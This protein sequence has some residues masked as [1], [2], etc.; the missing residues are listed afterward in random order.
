M[1][2]LGKAFNDRGAIFGA[3]LG[4]GA[5]PTGVSMMAPGATPTSKDTLGSV[6]LALGVINNTLMIGFQALAG[7]VYG[8]GSGISGGGGGGGGGGGAGGGVGIGARSPTM[9]GVVKAVIGNTAASYAALGDSVFKQL[10]QPANKMWS[11]GFYGTDMLGFAASAFGKVPLAGQIIG[12]FHDEAQDADDFKRRQLRMF[13]TGGQGS[14]NAFTEGF[15][16]RDLSD[17]DVTWGQKMGIGK[18]IGDRNT[19]RSGDFYR[20]AVR[21]GYG[22]SEYEGLV[23]SAARQGA[24]VQ[25][26]MDANGAPI[27]VSGDQ[28]AAFSGS[29]RR[30][31]AQGDNNEFAKMLGVSISSGLE[32]G[33]WGEMIT[34]ATRAAQTTLNVAVNVDQMRNVANFVQGGGGAMFQPGTPNFENMTKSY[35]GLAGDKNSIFAQQ[36]AWK[37]SGGNYSR[38]QSILAKSGMPGGEM[39]PKLVVDQFWDYPFVQDWFVTVNRPPYGY[40]GDLDQLAYA[41]GLLCQGAP[42]TPVPDMENILVMKAHEQESAEQLSK[43][44][45][46]SDFFGEK[47]VLPKTAQETASADAYRG[48]TAGIGGTQGQEILVPGRAGSTGTG[49]PPAPPSSPSGMFHPSTWSN[50]STQ[51]SSEGSGGQPVGHWTDYITSPMGP[52]TVNGVP[53]DHGMHVDLTFPAGAERLMSPCD[54]KVTMV[55]K[56]GTGNEVG[57]W[58]SIKV[59][60][61]NKVVTLGHLVPSTIAVTVGQDVYEGR[62][63]I[64]MQ[65]KTDFSE[66]RRHVDVGVTGEDGKPMSPQDSGVNFDSMHPPNIAP[67]NPPATE[68]APGMDGGSGLVT[69]TGAQ[70]SIQFEHSIRVHVTDARTTVASIGS[71]RLARG[72][73]LKGIS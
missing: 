68:S 50:P 39:D 56:G 14:M 9:N 1:N 40:R 46:T 57:G 65:A 13:R 6:V 16:Q 30:A 36:A 4:S 37:L 43:Y 51:S 48:R 64:G 32:Q 26:V 17:S 53:S 33:R 38:M 20:Y 54:G 67:R 18:F 34:W 11:S 55:N 41:A 52:R 66:G 47:A 25:T 71:K 63:Y 72:Q 29:M 44:G 61:S 22:R 58:V 27:G 8:G 15:T 49:A 10:Y 2:L 59:K 70:S 73:G 60:G 5:S 21:Y 3:L 19:E 28:A 69:P 45:N 12:A 42:G 7:G 24:N 31:G 35:A 62:T 23:G